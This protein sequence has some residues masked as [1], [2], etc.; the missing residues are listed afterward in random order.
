[1]RAHPGRAAQAGDRVSATSIRRVLRH[2]G[3]GPV[4]RGGPTWSEF[5]RAQASVVLAT[6]FFTVNTISLRQ[7]YVLF[8]IELGTR[9]VAILG[10]TDH[11]TATF[12]TQVARNLVGDLVDRG[13]SIKFLIRDRDAKFTASF[14]EVFASE[15]IRVIKTPVHSPRANAYAEGWVRT[16]RTE[17]LDWVLILGRRH[18]NAILRQ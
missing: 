3:L 5:L 17:C 7:L 15:G 1:M 8:V 4:P 13:R 10:V 2:H 16:V 9:E 14:D 11:P 12:V 6:D 18:L